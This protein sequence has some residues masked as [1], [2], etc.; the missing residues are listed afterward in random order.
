MKRR[1]GQGRG[2][3]V[4]LALILAASAALRLGSGVGAA[5]ATG[6]EEPVAEVMPVTP[7]GRSAGR[8]LPSCS[9]AA[10]VEAKVSTEVRV[11]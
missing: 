8:V 3:L 6:A 7:L 9:T 1:R 10:P 2:P 11:I 4:I 5:M